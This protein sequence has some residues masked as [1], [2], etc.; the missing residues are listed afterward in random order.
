MCHGAAWHVPSARGVS[1]HEEAEED[2]FI[3]ATLKSKHEKQL[4]RQYSQIS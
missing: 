2:S 1:S 4:K 3:S